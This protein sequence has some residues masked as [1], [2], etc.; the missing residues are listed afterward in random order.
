MP[1]AEIGTAGYEAA[2]TELKG[3]AA[4]G[5][6]YVGG[7]TEGSSTKTTPSMTADTDVAG[8]YNTGAT[9]DFTWLTTATEDSEITALGA[10]SSGSQAL[11][12]CA[13][14][15]SVELDYLHDAETNLPTSEGTWNSS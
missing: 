12:I 4:E 6:E 11:S 9:A 2:Y 14:L 15:C 1:G 7:C 5:D 8:G 10:S 13:L 3:G